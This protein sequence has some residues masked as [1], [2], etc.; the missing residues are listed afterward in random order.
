M[1]IRIPEQMRKEFVQFCEAS[2]TSA[3]GEIRAFIERQLAAKPLLIDGWLNNGKEISNRHAQE[4]EVLLQRRRTMNERHALEIKGAEAA[5]TIEQI[6]VDRRHGRERLEM[7]TA[8]EAT[9][10]RHSGEKFAHKHSRT[11]SAA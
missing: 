11:L 9:C 2:G 7:D 5:D 1:A 4:R 6:E 3:S 8:I 10:E